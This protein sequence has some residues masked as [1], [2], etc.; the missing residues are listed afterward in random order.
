VVSNLIVRGAFL[1][2]IA[3]ATAKTLLIAGWYQS[4]I[5]ALLR[6]GVD[7]DPISVCVSDRVSKLSSTSVGLPQV[8]ANAF[9][10]K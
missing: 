5:P 2:F 4:H 6:W 8:A 10:V 7:D 1:G 3:G 9:V